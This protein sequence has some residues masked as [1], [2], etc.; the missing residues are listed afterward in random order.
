MAEA[1]L[2]QIIEDTAPGGKERQLTVTI[3]YANP[4]K[5]LIN[6]Q[7]GSDIT[8]QYLIK[9]YLIGSKKY[10]KLIMQ[11]NLLCFQTFFK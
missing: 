10:N 4:I 7:G 8:L 2:T 6:L 9:K 3:I 1:R 5:I 11:Q